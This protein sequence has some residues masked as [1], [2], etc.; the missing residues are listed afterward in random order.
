[1]SLVGSAQSGQDAT[2]TGR[3]YAER[4]LVRNFALGI[5]DGAFFGTYLVLADVNLVLP[6]LLSHTSGRMG[7]AARIS[8]LN[9]KTLYEKLHQYSIRKEDFKE[10]TRT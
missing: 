4:H 9:E 7:D 8:G 3:T 6:W 1:M 5:T 2:P 10:P